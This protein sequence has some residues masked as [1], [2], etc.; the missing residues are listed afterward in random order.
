M[1]ESQSWTTQDSKSLVNRC[2]ISRVSAIRLFTFTEIEL[3]QRIEI[4]QRPPLEPEKSKII[5]RAEKL[6]PHEQWATAFG[7]V[8]LKPPFCKSS[9]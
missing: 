6:S 4:D 1:T 9:L 5:G 7:L 2:E 3:A 8:T